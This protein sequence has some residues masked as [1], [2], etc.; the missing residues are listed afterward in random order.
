MVSGS[1][2]N[3]QLVFVAI[4]LFNLLQFPLIVFPSVI[5]SVIEAM[6]SFGRVEKFL[7]AEELDLQAVIRQDYRTRDFDKSTERIELVSITNG[8]FKWDKLNGVILEDINLSVKKGDLTA[9][10][11]KVGE[12][13]SS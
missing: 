12:Y 3:A 11:G 9:I 1:P 10:V 7:L 4:P 8:E 13:N 5:T 2:L 6:V